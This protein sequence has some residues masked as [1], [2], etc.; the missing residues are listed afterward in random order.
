MGANTRSDSRFTLGEGRNGNRNSTRARQIYDAI[1]GQ[2]YVV[3]AGWYTALVWVPVSIGLA[4]DGQTTKAVILFAFG[5]IVVSSADNVLRP[6]FSKWGQLQMH[7]V[8]V[9][10]AMLGG[11]VAFGGWGLLLGPLLTRLAIEALRIFRE[12]DMAERP[13]AADQA[14]SAAP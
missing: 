9:L 5:A 3:S 10:L 4:L 14:S 7:G 2:N 13:T 6:L 11:V 8:I 12:E 1:L